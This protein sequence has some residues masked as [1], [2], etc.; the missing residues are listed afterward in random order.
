M[1][2]EFSL[3]PEYSCE[4]LFYHI[5]K[6]GR[7]SVPLSL[8]QV[9]HKWNI[10]A[11]ATPQLWVTI[12]ANIVYNI[13]LLTL[14]LQRSGVYPLAIHLHISPEKDVSSSF[15]RFSEGLSLLR[16]NLY[17]CRRLHSYGFSGDVGFERLFPA[18]T[19]TETPILRDLIISHPFPEEEQRMGSVHA[20]SLQTLAL[21][22]CP[23]YG[24]TKAFQPSFT[25][26]QHLTFLDCTYSFPRTKTHQV[27]AFLRQLPNLR[28][29]RLYIPSIN[30]P[31]STL[32]GDD[33]LLINLPHLHTMHVIWL[34]EADEDIS[35]FF[36]HINVP[37]LR[38]LHL[39]AHCSL[40]ILDLKSG[41]PTQ[42]AHLQLS[43]FEFSITGVKFFPFNE[44]VAL[45]EVSFKM[46]GQV[47][48]LLE[49]CMTHSNVCPHLK[50]L[51]FDMCIF[52][53]KD[54]VVKVIE[55]RC[56]AALKLVSLRRCRLSEELQAW[57][58]GQPNDL[59]RLT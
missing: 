2:F 35:Q 36:R 50:A 31:N 53:E 19:H 25:S 26:V 33:S 56:S 32:E 10:V 15:S 43:H 45:E 51:V 12:Y 21:P 13:P 42:I 8:P 37:S 48:M 54:I 20:P 29:C 49:E 17:R 7:R 4:E 30:D 24:L 16:Q 14:F 39:Q 34:G 38:R 58:G 59:V 52:K 55:Q 44:L 46:C 3:L 11:L 23:R 5:P 18:G 40:G 27:I 1:I 41:F 28:E 9:C 22:T 6:I 57:I 47:E